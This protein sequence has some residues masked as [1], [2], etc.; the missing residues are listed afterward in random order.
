MYICVNVRVYIPPNYRCDNFYLSDKW[1]IFQFEKSPKIAS[2]RL[3]GLHISKRYIR[4]R[5]Q[6]IRLIKDGHL[7]CIRQTTRQLSL[8]VPTS[9]KDNNKNVVIE[10]VPNQKT[11][12]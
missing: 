6:R 5:R 11:L 10:Q 4:T 8:A 1:C 2:R 7:P 12:F 3:Y 9:K